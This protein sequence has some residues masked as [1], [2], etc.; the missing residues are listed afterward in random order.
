MITNQLADSL[1]RS[2]GIGL[3]KTFEKQLTPPAPHTGGL[4]PFPPT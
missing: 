3:A 2:G 1:S 4:K